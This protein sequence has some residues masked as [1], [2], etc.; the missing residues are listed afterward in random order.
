MKTKMLLIYFFI[1]AIIACNGGGSGN[2]NYIEGVTAM[3]SHVELRLFESADDTEVYGI[4]KITQKPSVEYD[5]AELYFDGEIVGVFDGVDECIFYKIHYGDAIQCDL[6]FYQK[7]IIDGVETNVEVFHSIE[8]TA[9]HI[10]S[11][12]IG[13]H[14]DY[15]HPLCKQAQGDNRSFNI[16]NMPRGSADVCILFE[17]RVPANCSIILHSTTEKLTD[18]D[19]WTDEKLEV[20]YRYGDYKNRNDLYVSPDEAM[21][22]IDKEIDK[23]IS[24]DIILTEGIYSVYIVPSNFHDL[25]KL[26]FSITGDFNCQLFGTFKSLDLE[27]LGLLPPGVTP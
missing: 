14:A 4:A 20:H 13:H 7:Q 24:D 6:I 11:W 12:Y 8:T 9:L 10:C 1:V 16:S 25:S 3:T 27:K 19:P 18:T 26:V 23:W 22:H 17:I 2:K 5:Y 21:Y 15:W